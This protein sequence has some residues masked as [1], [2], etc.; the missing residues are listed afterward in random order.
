MLYV[1]LQKALYGLLKSLW[2]FYKKLLTDLMA[3]GFKPNPYDLCVVNKVIKGKQMTIAW[4]VDDLKVS[5]HD[6]AKIDELT[7]YIASIYSKITMKCRR[8]CDYLGIMVD[9]REK[10]KCKITIKEYTKKYWTHSPRK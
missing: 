3:I 10:G 2:P 5:H 9:Y 8:V 6:P 1:K 7:K 4:H